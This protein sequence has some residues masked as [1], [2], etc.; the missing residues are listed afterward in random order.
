MSLYQHQQTGQ[1]VELISFHDK[2]YAMI[3]NQ[4]GSVSYAALADLHEYKPGEGR[5]GEK[6]VAP[7]GQEETDPE[8][9]PTP[10][11]PPD[12][13]LNLNLATAEMIANRIKGVGYSTAK[14][15][16]E[17]RMSLPGERFQTLEQVKSIGR[18]DWDQVIAEDLVF[19][20]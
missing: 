16:I 17:L 14:K 7:R 20:G 3:R 1:V 4:S 11:I 9:I 8:V 12:T 15:V 19:V 5:T 18:V 10:V 6:P 13:R 2:D